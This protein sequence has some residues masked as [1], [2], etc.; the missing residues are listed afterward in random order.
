MEQGKKSRLMFFLATAG[1]AGLSPV[2]PGTCGSL[3][4]V[5]LHLAVVFALPGPW[6]YAALA[7][8]FLLACAACVASA[9]W[10]AERWGRPDPGQVV[11]DEVAGYLLVPLLFPA[12]GLV[13]TVVGGFALFRV[14]DASKPPP[15]R[16]MEHWFPRGWGVLAD[17]LL[18]GAVTAGLLHLGVYAG[19]FA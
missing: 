15:I 8:L 1:G 10:A 11:A 6:R 12:G 14:L 9:D 19:L 3:A 16:Q 13:Y 17:D 18:A 7:A 2:A 4:A 5:G